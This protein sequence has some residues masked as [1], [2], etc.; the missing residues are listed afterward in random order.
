MLWVYFKQWQSLPRREKGL[1]LFW[2]F[3][4]LSMI[5][6]GPLMAGA[7]FT[8]V[9]FTLNPAARIEGLPLWMDSAGAF[10]I[11]TACFG[12]LFV[13]A[14]VGTLECALRMTKRSLFKSTVP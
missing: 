13:A 14:T 3:L 6:L 7:A 12:V 10:L 11:V 1:F 2:G 4:T 5:V 9:G 8:S